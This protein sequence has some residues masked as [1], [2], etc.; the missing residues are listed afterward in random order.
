MHAEPVGEVVTGLRC[1]WAAKFR[2]LESASH[3]ANAC[4]ASMQINAEPN[5]IGGS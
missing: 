2:E 3:D 5:G 1:G 4:T